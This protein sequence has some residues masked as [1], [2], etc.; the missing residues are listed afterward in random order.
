M[1]EKRSGRLRAADRV[2]LKAVLDRLVPPVDD[3]AGAGELGILPV[4]ESRA[5]RHRNLREALSTIM[6]AF[7][8]D[9]A[10]HAAGGFSA[11]PVEDQDASIRQIQATIPVQ[12]DTFLRLVYT[13][14]YMQPEVLKHIG[15]PGH[16]PQPQG[17]ELAP[18]DDAILE[19][20][21]ERTP[22]WRATPE[23][24][25]VWD[26]RDEPIADDEP[27]TQSDGLAPS[28]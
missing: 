14:Y 1:N 16:P 10:A 13:I 27:P 6:E 25:P 26:Y 19:T 7:S 12:F 11:L 15:A 21:R 8:L 5:R 9:L 3:L 20:A 28:Q 23:M 22:F 24:A 4:L 18:W 17:F 2:V